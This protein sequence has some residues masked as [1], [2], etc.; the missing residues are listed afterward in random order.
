MYEVRWEE[1]RERNISL[2]QIDIHKSPFHVRRN[3]KAWCQLRKVM[4]EE[5]IDII[6]C[7]NPEEKLLAKNAFITINNEDYER[8]RKLR[9]RQGGIVRKIPGVGIETEKFGRRSA[10]RVAVR[11]NFTDLRME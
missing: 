8:A 4:R 9:L 6:H 2:H 3:F 11:K 10:D 1:L 5:D 7:H